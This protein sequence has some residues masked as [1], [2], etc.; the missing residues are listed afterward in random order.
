[1]TTSTNGYTNIPGIRHVAEELD[2]ST[3]W[4]LLQSSRSGRIGFLA[5]DRIEIFPV[6]HLVEEQV[7]YFRTSEDGLLAKST[8]QP[9]ASFQTDETQS[10]RMTGWSILAS[11]PLEKVE[12]ASVITF[13]AGRQWDEPWAEGLQAIFLRLTPGILTGRSF[14]MD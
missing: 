13:L 14:H 6:N 12:D 8:P 9:T 11:G 2:N 1:M 10:A 3:C 5:G 4:Q 7:V